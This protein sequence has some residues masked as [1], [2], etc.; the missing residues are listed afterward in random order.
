MLPVCTG[1]QVMDVNIKFLRF[2]T[3]YKQKKMC[4]C[5]NMKDSTSACLNA[6][7]SKQLA[8]IY[9]HTHG[10]ESRTHIQN[11]GNFV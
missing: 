8:K 7:P 5:A 3:V 6:Y 9:I 11:G 1:I 2:L 4:I 10:F